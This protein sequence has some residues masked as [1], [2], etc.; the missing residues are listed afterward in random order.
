MP[1][2]YGANHQAAFCYKISSRLFLPTRSFAAVG[3]PAWSMAEELDHLV[4]E[5]L[6]GN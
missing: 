4:I 6:D 3:L 1:A 2:P 5:F